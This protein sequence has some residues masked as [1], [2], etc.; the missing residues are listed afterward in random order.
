MAA[1]FF[2]AIVV[3]LFLMTARHCAAESGQM[4]KRKIRSTVRESRMPVE[5]DYFR[6]LSFFV[7][8]WYRLVS[9][10]WR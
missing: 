5:N 7:T 3:G 9:V 10:L 6:S 1:E 4:V 8:V 2:C